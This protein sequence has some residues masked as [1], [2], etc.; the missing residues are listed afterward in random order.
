MKQAKEIDLYQ[1]VV[2]VKKRVWM[3]LVSMFLLTS[4]A[5]V[6]TFFVVTP[7]Y[8]SATQMLVKLPTTEDENELT[9]N[10]INVNLMFIN[11][12]KDFAKK[13]NLIAS[14]VQRRLQDTPMK[15][16]TEK[17]LSNMVTLGNTS[18]S[19]MVTLTA[20]ANSPYIAAEIANLT[21]EVFKEKADEVMG[22]D[23]L[24]VIA[25]ATPE[26]KPSSPNSKLNLVIGLLLGFVFGTILALIV[27]FLDGTVKGETDIEAMDLL[28]LAQISEMDAEK[29]FRAI[30][31]DRERD[32][33]LREQKTR[34]ERYERQD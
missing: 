24:T 10:D 2:I 6:Y 23:K 18:N 30:E 28:V 7:K 31:F 19:Q 25:K 21:A 15:N 29:E 20:E 16:L 5:S 14:E 17:E 11:T 8:K 13:G 22:V 33:R 1:L 3:V 32:A 34:S 12:Y 4:L 27:E 9:V 26:T